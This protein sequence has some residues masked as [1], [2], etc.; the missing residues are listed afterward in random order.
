MSI[1]QLVNHQK[2]NLQ[3][4]LVIELVLDPDFPMW[5]FA[6]VFVSC[7]IKL[8]IFR[9]FLVVTF[10]SELQEQCGFHWESLDSGPQYFPTKNPPCGVFCLRMLHIKSEF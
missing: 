10:G 6:A 1:N 4:F 5:I 7:N 9:D 3:L 8:N 2:I